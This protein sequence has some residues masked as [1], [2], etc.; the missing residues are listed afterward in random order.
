VSQEV[1]PKPETGMIV[2]DIWNDDFE[3]FGRLIYEELAV[4]IKEEDTVEDRLVVNT[5]VLDTN[6]VITRSKTKGAINA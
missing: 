3:D 6:T 1:N 5:I 4:T 2:V